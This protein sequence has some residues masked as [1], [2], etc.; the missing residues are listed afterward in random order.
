VPRQL[1]LILLSFSLLADCSASNF[2][3]FASVGRP[4]TSS[5]SDGHRARGFTI[6]HNFG[7]SNDGTYPAS[8]MTL[9]K[10]A[11]YGTTIAGPDSNGNGAI[12]SIDVASGKEQV[13]HSFASGSQ[14]ARE[15]FGDLLAYKDI[16]YGTTFFGGKNQ[17]VIYTFAPDSQQYET[18]YEFHG[19]HDG[20]GPIGRLVML[21]DTLYGVTASG[22]PKA[23]GAVFSFDTQTG[24]ERSY[25]SP[26]ENP[27]GGLTYSDGLLF[28]G[29]SYDYVFS[30]DPNSHKS[31]LVY[32]F[33]GGLDGGGLQGELLALKGYLYGTTEAGGKHNEGTL[34]KIN[35]SSGSETVLFNFAGSNG[36]TSTAGVTAVGGSLYGVTSAG[37]SSNAGV[38]FQYD[39]AANREVTLHNFKPKRDGSGPSQTLTYAAGVLFGTTMSGG[40]SD[41]GTAFSI[42]P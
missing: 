29:C 31:A 33:S 36:A 34:F 30:F 26:C 4:D 12:Y 25:A 13:V 27:V 42:T 6:L 20:G 22:G 17:G 7:R 1:I 9:F 10:N 2:S 32:H 37:G 18:V 24:I 28:G 3:P 21:G 15:P 5:T 40:L 11:L 38:L 23:S 41:G 39:L 16:L 19:E 8:S 14:S 35:P